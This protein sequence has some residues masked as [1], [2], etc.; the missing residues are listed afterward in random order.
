MSH[1]LA[2]PDRCDAERKAAAEQQARSDKGTRKVVI[3][4]AMRKVV[5]DEAMRRVVRQ[6]VGECRD[7]GI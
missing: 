1:S 7:L 2:G 5:I 3:G 4:E 6:K